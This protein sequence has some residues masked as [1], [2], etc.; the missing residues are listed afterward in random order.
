M[1]TVCNCMLAILHNSAIGSS[2]TSGGGE[3]PELLPLPGLE[4]LEY[5]LREPERRGPGGAT[6]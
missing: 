3:L 4:S 6:I 2:H 5:T 1:S